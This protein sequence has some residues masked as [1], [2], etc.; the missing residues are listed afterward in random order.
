VTQVVGDVG[1]GVLHGLTDGALAITDDCPNGHT[2]GPFHLEQKRGQVLV[3][4]GQPAL[5]Q[6]DFAGEAV[7]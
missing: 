4:R 6:E 3:A 7:A 1:Q 2:E 5:G